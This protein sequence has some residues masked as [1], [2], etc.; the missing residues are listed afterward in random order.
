MRNPLDL[1]LISVSLALQHSLAYSDANK[2]NIRAT[3]GDKNLVNI[4]IWDNL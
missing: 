2:M 1:P 4:L 3:V